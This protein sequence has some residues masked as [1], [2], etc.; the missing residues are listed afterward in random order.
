MRTLL[1]GPGGTPVVVDQSQ[2]ER[3][4]ALLSVAFGM[5]AGQ[6][7]DDRH[8]VSKLMAEIVKVVGADVL[9]LAYPNLDFTLTNV[10]PR[11]K[12]WKQVEN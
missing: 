8:A 6:V 12:A 5:I 2:G 9:K 3:A 4:L 1:Y 7:P 11:S 10:P